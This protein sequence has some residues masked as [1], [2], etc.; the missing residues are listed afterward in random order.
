MP[1]LREWTSGAQAQAREK[2]ISTANIVFMQKFT[3]CFPFFTGTVFAGFA[4]GTSFAFFLFFLELLVFNFF[5][6][7]ELSV[8]VY[9]CGC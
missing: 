5:L 8:I 2:I 7:S 4:L 9:L 3:P 6:T 1:I